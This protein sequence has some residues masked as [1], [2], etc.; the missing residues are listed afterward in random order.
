MHT[1]FEN[2][3]LN[4]IRYSMVWEG[5]S[6]LYRGLDIKEDDKLLLITSAGCNVLN[7]LLKKPKALTAI[8]INPEQNRLMLLKKHIIEKHDYHV[9]WSA[10]GF[11]GKAEVKKAWLKVSDTLDPVQQNY[12]DQFFRNN[13]EGLLSA[14]KLERYIHDFYAGLPVV[15]QKKVKQLITFSNLKD[16][17]RFFDKELDNEDFQELFIH[18]FDK[19]NLSKGRDPKLFKYVKESGGEIF[20]YRLKDF[21]RKNLLK[22]NFN[23]QF[24]MFGAENIPQDILPPCYQQKNYELLR[25][26]I[27]HLE[28][29]TGEAVDYLLS[30]KGKMI[31]KAG[32][33][34]I[35]EYVDEVE[36]SQVCQKIFK[37]RK[38]PLKII[39]W[40]LL[41]SQGDHHCKKFILENQSAELSQKES[42]F[43]FKNV[44]VM[45][46]LPNL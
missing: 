43:Y 10:M 9:F 33:S 35:F 30:E 16:Q 27:K 45:E 22:K 38:Q 5:A 20:Y 36:F 40:N 12:W 2:V 29:V 21:V 1:E 4:L 6:T 26:Q 44:R 19:Q 24:F 13:P 11:G 23:F 32:L 31:T 25:K 17:E 28:I 37:A 41:Q 46:T 18:Y 8:D 3:D 42:C 7:A 15:I 39:Y 34:N 14:G